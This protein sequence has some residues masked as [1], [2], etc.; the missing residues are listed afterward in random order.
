LREHQQYNQTGLFDE[1]M[2]TF[3]RNVDVRSSPPLDLPLTDSRGQPLPLATLKARA[4]L[5]D[6]ETGVLD[7][8]LHRSNLCEL[9]D[10][11]QTVASVSG[12]GNNWAHGHCHYGPK[13]GAGVVEAVRRQAE[14]CD[15]L[16]AFFLMHSLGGG[17]GSGLGTYILGELEQQYAD[18]YR[19]VTAVFPS[20]QD[21]VVT[22]PYNS[23]LAL[24]ELIAHADAAMPIHNQAL[25]DICERINKPRGAGAAAAAAAA[26]DARVAGVEKTTLLGSSAA[27]SSSPGDSKQQREKRIRAF[28]DMN[29]ISAQ[30]LTSLT[31]SMRFEGPLNVDL[32]EIT[33]NLVP[34]PRMHFLVSSLAPLYTSAKDN[35]AL[36]FGGAAAPPPSASASA[37]AALGLGP[38][39]RMKAAKDASLTYG[40][41]KSIDAM[42][43]TLFA[44]ES[45]LVS[46]SPEARAR[47]CY[48]ACGLFGR[49][50]DLTV[51]D[52]NR[53]IARL[54]RSP[55]FRMVDWNDDGFKIGLCGT[56]PVGL[57]SS[58]LSLSNST[59]VAGLMVSMRER[60]MR[61]YSRRAH[62]HHYLE[63]MEEERMDTALQRI[64]AV[65][66]DYQRME[67]N[68]ARDSEAEARGSGLKRMQPL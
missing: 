15:S 16:Q 24:G 47:S 18:I 27:A 28:D 54:R 8:L 55:N 39:A 34:F 19:F 4:V 60:V 46:L 26:P 41:S 14:H 59:S 7:E 48:L 37:A 51:A 22:S 2:S 40:A 42:F 17:T 1:S 9:F 13:Y 11:R 62:F 44:P 52:L 67:Y 33:M 65:I 53:N 36:K 30:L 23:C 25:I 12:S 45:H 61:L 10:E 38:D 35:L 32:N 21:D 64:D 66:A 3:F 57:R 58:L 56:P 63:Y 29:T 5:V 6:M 68:S 20:D 50:A 43:T 31:C 49:G